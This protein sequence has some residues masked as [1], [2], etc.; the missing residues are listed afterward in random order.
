MTNKEII[1]AFNEN[2]ADEVMDWISDEIQYLMNNHRLNGRNSSLYIKLKKD[3]YGFYDIDLI[4]V[5]EQGEPEECAELL[6]SSTKDSNYQEKEITGYDILLAWLFRR[7][8]DLEY[9]E[10]ER[11][12]Y[13]KAV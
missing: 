9:K 2:N 10:E 1:Q 13:L 8:L 3:E 12:A 7:N 6:Y 11:T 5:P 4:R